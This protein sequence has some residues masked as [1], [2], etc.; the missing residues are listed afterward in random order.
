MSPDFKEDLLNTKK[1]LLNYVGRKRVEEIKK[2]SGKETAKNLNVPSV[3]FYGERE[4][5]LY[6]QLKIRCEET[7]KLANNSKLI[8]VKG[9]PHKMDHIEYKN[10]LIQELEKMQ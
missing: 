3:I 4:A 10:S 7:A 2:R 6:P 9:A 1:W 5:D 8:I